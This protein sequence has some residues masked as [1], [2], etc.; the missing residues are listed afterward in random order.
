M[1]PSP[2]TI[3]TSFVPKQPV[4]S[5]TNFR[6]SGGNPFLTVSL[7][8]LVLALVACGA[9]FGYER[10][11]EGVRDA[12]QAQVQQAQASVDTAQLSTFIRARDR[13][14]AAEGLLNG[15]V[16]VSNFLSLLEGLTLTNVRFA[17]LN[18]QLAD[19]RSAEIKMDGI[20]RTFNALA[21][22][23]SAFAGEKRIKRAIFSGIKVNDNGTVSFSLDANIEPDL[24]AFTAAG[25]PAAPPVPATTTPAVASSSPQSAAPVSDSAPVTP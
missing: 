16:A 8:I 17:S 15:H 9:V 22:E 21:A 5:T 18:F 11:L 23:S 2:T 1:A 6:K 19:D 24:L 4:R 10:Y 12:K 20:A 7:I 25:A 14:T 13:F 3:P